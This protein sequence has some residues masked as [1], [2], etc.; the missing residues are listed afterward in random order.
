M[1]SRV[2]FAPDSCETRTLQC[3]PLPVALPGATDAPQDG[4]HRA[5]NRAWRSSPGQVSLPIKPNQRTQCLAIAQIARRSIRVA[6]A[7]REKYRVAIV[8]FVDW[9]ETL[10]VN[11]EAQSPKPSMRH[12]WPIRRRLGKRVYGQPYRG[13]EPAPSATILAANRG[14]GSSR[15]NEAHFRRVPGYRKKPGAARQP[16]KA[17][18]A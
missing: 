13:F 1:R 3:R 12:K 18:F 5:L 8:R 15:A 16:R 10:H 7:R 4:F 2:G 11:L 6:R 9:V 14:C 17:K